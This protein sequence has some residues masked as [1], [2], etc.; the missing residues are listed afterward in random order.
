M[1][2]KEFFLWG[3][4]IVACLSKLNAQLLPTGQWRTHLSYKIPLTCEATSRFVYA[5]SAEGFWKTSNDGEMTK[6][7]PKDGFA[8]LEVSCLKF[9]PQ[10]NALIIGYANGNIDVL[11]NDRILK[12]IPGFYNKPLQGDKRINHIE[13]IGNEALVST[14]FGLLMVDLDKFEIKDSY[15]SIGTAGRDIKVLSSCVLGDSIYVGTNDGILSAKFSKTINLN[16]YNQWH[17]AYSGV[18]CGKMA[19]FND[20]LYFESDSII[21]AYSKG[22]VRNLFN[23]VNKRFTAALF[24]NSNGLHVVQPGQITNISNSGWKVQS[25]N[26][27]VAATQFSDGIYWFSTGIGPGIIKKDPAGEVAFMPNGPDDLSVWGM[28]KGGSQLVC[29]GG[30]MSN[31]FGNAFN[32]SGFYIYDNNGWANNM[33][34]PFNQNMYDFT[35]STFYKQKGT[36]WAATH[37]NGILVFKGKEII[38]R[39]DD[40]NSPLRRVQDSLQMH[41]A[42]LAEDSKGSM[43]I[44]NYQAAYPL[45]C[46]TKDGKWRSYTLRGT[47]E[48]KN[49]TIDANDRKWMIINGGILVFSEGKNPDD[50]TDDKFITLTPNNGLVSPEVLSIQCDKNGYVW[51]GTLQG[52]NVYTGNGDIFT[53]PKLDRFI[54]EQDGSTGYLMGEETINDIVIDGGNRKWCGTKNGLFCVDEYGQKVLKHF[55][56]ENSEIISNNIYCLGQIETTGE[57]FIGTDKGIVSYRSDANKG[58]ENFGEISVYPNPVPPKYDGII[59]IEGL[60]INSEIR[61]TDIQGKLVYQT[62]SNGGKATWNGKR[63]DGSIPNSG[64]YLVF[65]INADGTE[66]AMGKFIF[67]K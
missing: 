20:S 51:I 33:A 38:N 35:F 66:T 31:T 41:L 44:G 11:I 65:A 63:L 12:N 37:S 32:N 26:L 50:S 17:Y 28:S 45:H 3:I 47:T 67:I 56:V 36:Y 48:I 54:V 60:V 57:I 8:S 59:T 19:T 43:W 52:L 40:K 27:V 64:V 7:L 22:N 29:T 39:F 1:I 14:N 9:I 46:Y 62:K 6:L 21:L 53:N 61:I 34:S 15:S 18:N 4:L 55:S 16:D 2:R 23:T 5:A 30:G 58:N 13:S 10:K 42:G 25:I 49:V 24:T